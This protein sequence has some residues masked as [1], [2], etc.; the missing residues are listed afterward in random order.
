MSM[1][2]VYLLESLSRKST[3][4]GSTDNLRRRLREHN[5]GTEFS[6]KRYIPWRLVAYEAYQS[7]EDAR[8]REQKLKHH[9]NAIREFKRRAKNSFK[10]GA[11]FTLVEILVVVGLIGFIAALGFMVSIG[12]FQ[13]Y[14]FASE[15]D[16]VV[17]LLQKARSQAMNNVEQLPHG[18]RAE[19]GEYVLF[20]DGGSE[21]TFPKNTSVDVSP[22]DF[23][24]EFD[25]LS[26][27]VS[28][29]LEINLSRD[30]NSVAI[31][32]STNGRIDW[33]YE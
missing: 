24:V 18:V 21:I 26:G 33:H 23:E 6:T 30:A 32:I 5:L 7:E 27:E 3:Y 15:R 4:I 16:L 2:Y 31:D 8:G 28:G 11:G 17:S 10:N 13:R 20:A 14:A 25:Q 22:S 19:D 12:A 1:Y 9:G 29:D